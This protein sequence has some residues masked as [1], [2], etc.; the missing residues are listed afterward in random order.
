MEKLRIWDNVLKR[1]AQVGQKDY[2]NAIFTMQKVD[3]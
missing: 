2:F 3:F 1:V